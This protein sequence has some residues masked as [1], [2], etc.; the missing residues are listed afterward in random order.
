MMS[1]VLTG[2][3]IVMRYMLA[4][5]IYRYCLSYISQHLLLILLRLLV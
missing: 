2:P 1:Q 5:Q 4:D 3:Y